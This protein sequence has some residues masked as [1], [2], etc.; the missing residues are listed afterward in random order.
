MLA[1]LSHPFPTSFPS[2][3]LLKHDKFRIFEAGI[4]LSVENLSKDILFGAVG[5][6]ISEKILPFQIRL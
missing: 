1:T 5:F 4:F 2:L 3:P 6:N